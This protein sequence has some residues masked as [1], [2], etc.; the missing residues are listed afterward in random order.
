M[1]FRSKQYKLYQA[2][3]RCSEFRFWSFSECWFSLMKQ[4][5]RKYPLNKEKRKI[6]VGPELL[7]WLIESRFFTSYFTVAEVYYAEVD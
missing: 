2:I 3:D 6:P 7:H 4:T 5:M 1:F